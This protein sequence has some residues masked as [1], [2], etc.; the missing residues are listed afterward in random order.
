[1]HEFAEKEGFIHIAPIRKMKKQGFKIRGRL[2]KK[3]AKCFPKKKYHRRSIIEN[4]WFCV[5]KICGKVIFAKK[6]M[7][8]KKEMLAKVLAYNI[9]RLVKLRI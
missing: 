3:L 6:W 4:M 9:H 8:Q 7:M 2:R 1:M 5:K